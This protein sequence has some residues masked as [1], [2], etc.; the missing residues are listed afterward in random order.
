MRTLFS[1][2]ALVHQH[3]PIRMPHSAQAVRD[4]E[5]G[6]AL[7]GLLEIHAN[8]GLGVVIQGAGGFIKDQQIRVLQQGA[9]N[10]Y[11][12]VGHR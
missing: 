11:V 4:E 8:R 12:G 7:E 9:G 5:H 10:R 3:N 1:Q 2:R 6:F